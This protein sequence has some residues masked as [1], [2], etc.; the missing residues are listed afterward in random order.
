M[1]AINEG[2]E[3]N[4]REIERSFEECIWPNKGKWRMA[5]QSRIVPNI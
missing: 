5:V 1:W 2:D 3:N 4:I